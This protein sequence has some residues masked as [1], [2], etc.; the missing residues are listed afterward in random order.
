V[1]VPLK[2][3]TKRKEDED[4]VLSDRRNIVVI[5]EEA[6]RSLCRDFVWNLRQE[7]PNASFIGFTGMPIKLESR[8][9]TLVFGEPIGGSSPDKIGSARAWFRFIRRL[10]FRDFVRFIWECKKSLCLPSF[11]R[12]DGLIQ[13]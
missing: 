3:F 6:H 1:I 9:T 10:G 13:S 7:V 11:L 8:S 5:A 2:K 4:A 12:D